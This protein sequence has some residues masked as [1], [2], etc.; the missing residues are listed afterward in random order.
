MNLINKS[1]NLVP[2]IGRPVSRS[3][4]SER[5]SGEMTIASRYREDAMKHFEIVKQD[6][7][8]GE[9]GS[10]S[11]ERLLKAKD[12]VLLS[13]ALVV[14][15]SR[16]DEAKHNMDIACELEAKTKATLAEDAARQNFY[17]VESDF[18][19]ALQASQEA[20]ALVSQRNLSADLF[21]KY[22]MAEREL[23]PEEFAE[24][25]WKKKKE[26]EE[27]RKRY[28]NPP[29]IPKEKLTVVLQIK[30]SFKK[31]YVILKKLWGL[32]VKRIKS[33]IF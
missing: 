21:V 32:V 24:L 12:L 22:T 30:K 4:R 29:P 19:R 26:L 17:S 13:K 14:A 11:N 1:N 8:V 9:T 3:F 10:G 16:L 7:Q 15:A 6:F 27:R 20:D 31:A 5:M 28:T 23:G 33:S 25:M 2:P 18:L